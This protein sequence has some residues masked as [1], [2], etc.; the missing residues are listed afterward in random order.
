MATRAKEKN[1]IPIWNSSGP[2]S[3][4][5][6]VGVLISFALICNQVIELLNFEFD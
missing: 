2:E 3:D 4:G 5:N 6:G 1:E